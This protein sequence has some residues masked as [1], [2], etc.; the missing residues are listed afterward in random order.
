[1]LES[2]QVLGLTRMR[3]RRLV[4]WKQPGPPE[5]QRFRGLPTRRLRP[6]AARWELTRSQAL[7]RRPL[8]LPSEQTPP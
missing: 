1:M 6:L 3:V 4:S 7:A 2:V 5:P 8:A